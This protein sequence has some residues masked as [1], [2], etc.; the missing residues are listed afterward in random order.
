MPELMQDDED[1]Y[2]QKFIRLGIAAAFG[3]FLA[4]VMVVVMR[5]IA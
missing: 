1:P 5:L 4:V 2:R 3:L